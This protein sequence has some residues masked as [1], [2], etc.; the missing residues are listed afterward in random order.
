MIKQKNYIWLNHKMK[1][2]K[3]I[4]L[5]K[6]KEFYPGLENPFAVEDIVN[7]TIAEVGKVIDDEVIISKNEIIKGSGFKD[8]LTKLAITSIEEFAEE[9]KQKLGIK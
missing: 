6:V 8:G 1:N 5:K 3:N 2:I 7:W 9:L 4:V